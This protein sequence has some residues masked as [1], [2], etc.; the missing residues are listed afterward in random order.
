PLSDALTAA[1]RDLAGG[2]SLAA[3]SRDF[4]DAIRRQAESGSLTRGADGRPGGAVEAARPGRAARA[5]PAPG[6]SERN[7]RVVTAG[8][9]AAA[10]DQVREVLGRAAR[11]IDDP[12]AMQ[13]RG[14]LTAARAAQ[15]RDELSRAAPAEGAAEHLDPKI[16]TVIADNLAKAETSREGGI[17]VVADQMRYLPDDGVPKTISEREAMAVVARA[18]DAEAARGGDVASLLAEADAAYRAADSGTPPD[19]G[20]AEAARVAPAEGAPAPSETPDLFRLP[21]PNA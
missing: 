19:V 16:W 5:E 10:N 20:A 17:E 12:L 9:E 4:V 21:D 11:P 3:V 1:A 13:R 7:P 2:K 8:E 14:E 18:L 15:I 6:A